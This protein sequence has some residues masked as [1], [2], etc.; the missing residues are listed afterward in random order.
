ML[1]SPPPPPPPLLLLLDLSTTTAPTPLPPP[2]GTP[3]APESEGTAC[4]V[5]GRSRFEQLLGP[6]AQLM[7][8]VNS[9]REALRRQQNSSRKLRNRMI[10]LERMMNPRLAAE[11]EVSV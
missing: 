4:L 10:H 5:M 1:L 9:K 7:N 3:Q 2:R 6:L 8:A 11:L